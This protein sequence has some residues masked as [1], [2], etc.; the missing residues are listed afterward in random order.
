[1]GHWPVR[2]ESELQ[3]QQPNQNK[4]CTTFFQVAVQPRKGQRC[5]GMREPQSDLQVADV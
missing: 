3:L 4:E 1:M 5:G 2:R